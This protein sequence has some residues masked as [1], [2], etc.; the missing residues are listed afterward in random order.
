M[1]DAME[2]NSIASREGHVERSRVSAQPLT[3]NL[4]DGARDSASRGGSA[5]VGRCHL[6]RHCTLVT[7]PAYQRAAKTGR[8][9]RSDAVKP[10]RPVSVVSAILA[11]ISPRPD[12]D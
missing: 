3:V 4:V 1:V 11:L 7:R 2:R 6:H 5:G 9:E 12:V 10:Q 8:S